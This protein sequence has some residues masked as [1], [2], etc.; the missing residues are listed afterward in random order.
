MP[1]LPKKPKILLH[2]SRSGQE[3]VGSWWAWGNA[4]VVETYSDQGYEPNFFNDRVRTPSQSA[5]G[6]HSAN[7]AA[8]AITTGIDFSGDFT[9]DWWE[10]LQWTQR[11]ACTFSLNQN[12]STNYSGILFGYPVTNGGNRYLYISSNGTTWDIAN[13]VSLGSSIFNIWV[14]WALS[15]KGD[16][17]FVFKDGVQLA[18]FTSSL[19]IYNNVWANAYCQMAVRHNYAYLNTSNYQNYFTEVCLTDYC[20]Y[21]SAFTPPTDRYYF[22]PEVLSGYIPVAID[23]A[24][25]VY[26]PK[27]GLLLPDIAPAV[28]LKEHIAED[29]DAISSGTK[30]NAIHPANEV[31]ATLPAEKNR[32]HFAVSAVEIVPAG[33]ESKVHPAVILDEVTAGTRLLVQFDGVFIEPIEPT[34][35]A[36]YRFSLLVTPTHQYRNQ[37]VSV[38]SEPL[39]NQSLSG[40][41]QLSIGDQIIAPY[42]ENDGDI[43]YIDLVIKPDELVFGNNL[44]RIDFIY[45]DGKREYLDF[46]VFKETPLRQEV[47]RTFKHYD[48]GYIGDRM[49]AAPNSISA[50]PCFLVPEGHDSTI[51]YTT[52]DTSVIVDKYAGMLGVNMDAAG[53]RIYV[54]FDGRNTWKSYVTDEWESVLIEDICDQGMTVVFFNSLTQDQ[55]AEIYQQTQIDFAIYLN[56]SIS[57]YASSVNAELLHSVINSSS[58][59]AVPNDWS[60]TSVFYSVTG[61]YN[62]A[63]YH[64]SVY[65]EYYNGVATLIASS[66]NA[67]TSSGTRDF[68]DFSPERPEKLQIS[69]TSKGSGTL[70]VYGAR[71]LAYLKS[72]TVLLPPNQSPAVTNIQLA[73][74]TVHTENTILTAYIADAEGDPAYY[75]VLVN[76]E[77]LSDYATD[78]TEFDIDVAIPNELLIIGTSAIEIQT[79]DENT[80]STPYTIYITK[81][82]TLPTI[83]GVL[84]K[85][86]FTATV[87]DADGDKVRYRILMNGVL[88]QDWSSYESQPVN[89]AYTMKK[90]NIVIDHQN[91]LTLEVQDSL[92]ETTSVD[93]DFVGQYYGLLF[94]DVD[95]VLLSDD[96]GN[97]LKQLDFGVI[98]AG[99]NSEPQKIVVSNTT[100]DNLRDVVVTT[101]GELPDNP[102]TPQPET[103]IQFDNTMDFTRPVSE[104]PIASLNNNME[105]ELWMRVLTG[106]KSLTGGRVNL[107]AKGEVK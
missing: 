44:C 97:V 61:Y 101:E 20:R 2:F 69:V 58:T 90:A 15:R 29:V 33:K 24:E 30:N 88:V 49:N 92:G 71:Q 103:V 38:H 3:N 82:N 107:R 26:T 53:V 75:R 14:H 6:I 85:M 99:A 31:D 41:Y 94:K 7:Q 50:P 70:K 1:L 81:T 23:L 18:T 73:P 11:Y 8:E 27:N 105:S 22:E 86:N 68:G 51:I 95:G 37:V 89:L 63:T 106:R 66:R 32:M 72:I 9:L 77:P 46:E 45:S 59:F 76:G 100:G 79:W 16:T 4:P 12:P 21:D 96:E 42:A 10:Y 52:V 74:D 54:S 87:N 84:D 13:S 39:N 93:F 28:S 34:S 64:T 78:G 35:N 98:M 5:M 65:Y 67:Y 48:G 62:A 56:N 43:T 102:A 19:P 91:T 83:Y 25:V 80:Y 104:L 47:K 40:K 57:E 17:F 55:W 36:E 60:V